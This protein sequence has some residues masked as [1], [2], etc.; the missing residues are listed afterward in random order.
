[1]AF[2]RVIE[3]RVKYTYIM[4]NKKKIVLPAAAATMTAAVLVA[5]AMSPMGACAISPFGMNVPAVGRAWGTVDSIPRG[6]STGERTYR[7][8]ACRFLKT[9]GILARCY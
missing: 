9:L 4:T 5:A 2:G 7:S 6:G 3:E 8:T 1:M